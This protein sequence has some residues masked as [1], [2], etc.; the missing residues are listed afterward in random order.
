MSNIKR[1]LYR[2]S[3]QKLR[4]SCLAENNQL[5]GFNTDVG[6]Q[7]NLQ[8][9]NNYLIDA[10]D[11]NNVP[12]Y[13]AQE[14]LRMNITL[15]QEYACRVWRVLN[16]LNAVRMGYQGQ[17]KG[18]SPMDV[19]VGEFRDAIQPQHQG[20]LV[21]QAEDRW[22]WEVVQA[23]LEDM[24]ISERIW[25]TRIYSDLNRRRKVATKRRWRAG[26]DDVTET[27]TELVHFMAIADE[28]NRHAM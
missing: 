18:G 6:T 4:V 5:G 10:S 20:G 12:D 2:P 24:W 26:V 13:V 15:E 21:A 1:V 9:L 22:N 11:V 23:E 17:R 14:N 28:I 25:F 8:R 19:A 27:R 7:D 3:W 16:M